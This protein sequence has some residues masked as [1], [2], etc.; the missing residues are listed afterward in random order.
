MNAEC[1]GGIFPQSDSRRL[2][3]QH[4]MLILMDDVCCPGG[5]TSAGRTPDHRVVARAKFELVGRGTTKIREIFHQE[6]Y[7]FDSFRTS[8]DQDGCRSF[9][10][11]GCRI[12]RIA[13]KRCLQEN[14]S[15]VDQGQIVGKWGSFGPQESGALRTFLGKSLELN[16][17]PESQE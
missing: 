12:L 11:F 15:Q 3:Y 4:P 13:I 1:V 16:S 5:P 7:S 6:A 2:T 9:C 17:E 14:R 10:P 8:L